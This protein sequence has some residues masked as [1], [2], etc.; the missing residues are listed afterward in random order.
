MKQ[1][2][3][4]VEEKA[5]RA[6]G[7]M[8]AWFRHGHALALEVL[9]VPLLWRPLGAAVAEVTPE[10]VSAIDVAPSLLAEAGIAAPE[11][12]SGRKLPN[13]ADPPDAPGPPRAAFAELG[14]AVAVATGREFYV[15]GR[16]P[17]I[18]ARLAVLPDDGGPA[19]FDPDAQR[20]RGVRIDQLETRILEYRA[21]AAPPRERPAR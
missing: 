1:A 7:E 10:P 5:S 2:L 8:G 13:A 19:R 14:D 21:E 18:G 3:E 9:R 11:A 20:T 15:R 16:F 17:R 4:L 6:A 12:W